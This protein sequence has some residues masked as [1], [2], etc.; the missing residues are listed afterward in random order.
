[1]STIGDGA[2]TASRLL[3]VLKDLPLWILAGLAI[4]LDVLLFVPPIATEL[5]ATF[6]PWLVVFAVLLNFLAGARV[7]ALAIDKLGDFRKT[8][9]GRRTFHLSP[10]SIQAHWSTHRQRDDSMTTQITAQFMV[11]NLTDAPLGLVE[12]RLIRPKINGEVRHAD[13]AVRPAESHTY[14]SLH[15]GYRIPPGDV[16]PAALHLMIGGTPGQAATETL[17]ATF[18]ISDDEGNE[19][20][21]RV[22]LKGRPSSRQAE[23][24]I[25]PTERAFSIADPIEKE[26]VSVLQSE[27]GRYDKHGRE[28]GG[29]GSI[30]LQYEGRL[31]SGFGTDSWNPDSPKNQIHCRQA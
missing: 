12:P 30:H 5:P 17:H 6:R 24:P 29:F 26:I 2:D 8:R 16:A 22:A 14:G 21:I 10:E 1:M 27:I 13:I 11:K 28:R 9:A 19:Q 15:S 23:Q 31:V 3:G 18:G 7:I 20:R 25:N 4:G